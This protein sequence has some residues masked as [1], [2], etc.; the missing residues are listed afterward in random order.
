MIS[1]YLNFKC[2]HKQTN[3]QTNGSL[4]AI[5]KASAYAP[6]DH[7]ELE[8]LPPYP[9]T[10]LKKDLDTANTP[11]NVGIVHQPTLRKQED[12]MNTIFKGIL[13]VSWHA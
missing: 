13:L 5:L 1:W 8:R 2:L 3:R 9:S 11:F 4:T 6:A 12:N 10:W 7:R